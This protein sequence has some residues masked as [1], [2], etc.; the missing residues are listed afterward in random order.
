MGSVP[1]LEESGELAGSLPCED[2]RSLQPGRGSSQNP[3]VLTSSLQS[4]R[5][6]VVDEPPGLWCFVTAAR[7]DSAPDRQYPAV[8]HGESGHL[9]HSGGGG[10]EG[11]PGG[12]FPSVS[13]W[14][15]LWD[16]PP[17]HPPNRHS[18]FIAH[19]LGM[20]TRTRA[21]SPGHPSFPVLQ[22]V[23]GEPFASDGPVA[24]LLAVIST[25]LQEG[26]RRHLPEELVPGKSRATPVAAGAHIPGPAP[27]RWV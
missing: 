18:Q 24:R 23:G 13:S 5:K 20:P 6:Y 3:T 12:S 15:S 1:L 25:V 17:P 4:C 14:S 9:R 8:G 16:G 10:R 26:D 2:T 11:M 19:L 27:A 21:V 22:G 7:T